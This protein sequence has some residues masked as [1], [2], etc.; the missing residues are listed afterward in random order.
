MADNL[1]VSMSKL[2][3]VEPEKGEFRGVRAAAEVFPR[4]RPSP[5]R[6]VSG[7]PYE[8]NIV[9]DDDEDRHRMPVI[10]ETVRE[11]W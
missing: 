7:W 5:D 2:C 11:K 9:R 6:S 10:C 4:A 1:A 3:V 8:S